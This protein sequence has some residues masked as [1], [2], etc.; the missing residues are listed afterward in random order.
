[1]NK[2]GEIINEKGVTLSP[3]KSERKGLPAVVRTHHDTTTLISVTRLYDFLL[4]VDQ[5]RRHNQTDSDL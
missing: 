3:S 2:Y 1:M 4:Y 5:L